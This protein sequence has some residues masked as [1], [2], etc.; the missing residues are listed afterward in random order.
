MGR[1]NS[2]T[3]RKISQRTQWFD[4]ALYPFAQMRPGHYSA[5]ATN[6]ALE[7]KR[8]GPKAYRKLP[9]KLRDATAEAEK[10][11]LRMANARPEIDVPP[12]FQ[13]LMPKLEELVAADP[14]LKNYTYPQFFESRRLVKL[15]RI[16]KK[17]GRKQ[18]RAV[19]ERIRLFAEMDLK[20]ITQRK[21]APVLFPAL[22]PEKAYSETRALKSRQRR[23]IE[24][25]K[26]TMKSKQ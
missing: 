10:L 22:T 6:R 17:R 1:K 24:A 7:L 25:A 20:G 2:N 5:L 23:A 8:T 19:Q 12:D 18:S 3:P 26:N 21:M 4:P 11:S 13:K 14:E 15:A 16:P 9:K